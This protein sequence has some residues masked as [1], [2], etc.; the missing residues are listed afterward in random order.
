MHDGVL[1]GSKFVGWFMISVRPYRPAAEGG[2][3]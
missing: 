3:V 2:T 1:L